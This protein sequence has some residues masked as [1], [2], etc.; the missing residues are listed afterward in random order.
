MSYICYLRI[1]CIANTRPQLTLYLASS[2]DQY[3]FNLQVIYLNVIALTPCMIRL[4][5]S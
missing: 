1:V 2:V 5:V 3:L 4:N